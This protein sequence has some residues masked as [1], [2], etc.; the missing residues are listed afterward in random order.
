[1]P[2]VN[3]ETYDELMSKAQLVRVVAHNASTQK[4]NSKYWKVSRNRILRHKSEISLV[5]VLKNIV[6]T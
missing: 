1:M 3:N 5:N 6:L 4:E 2:Y